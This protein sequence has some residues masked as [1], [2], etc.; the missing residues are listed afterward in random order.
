MSEFDGPGL[1]IHVPFCTHI[2]PYCDF[3]VLTGDRSWQTRYLQHLSLEIELLTESGWPELVREPPSEAFDTIYFGGGTPSMLPPG[4]LESILEAV[5]AKMHVREERLAIPGGQSRGCHPGKPQ[6]PGA[7]WDFARSV[8]A[9]SP[10]P[11]TISPSWD[12]STHHGPRGGVST[13]PSPPD[14]IR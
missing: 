2:C 12:D 8:W 9:C 1:Y 13:T 14:S 4:N 7:R 3:S 6:R 10:S 11:K 5:R